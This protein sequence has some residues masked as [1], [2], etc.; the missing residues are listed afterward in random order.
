MAKMKDIRIVFFDVDGT[1]IDMKKKQISIRMLETLVRL[2]EKGVLLCLATGR[3]PMLLPHF[4]GVEFD[5]FLTFNGSYC[6]N[7]EE[8]ILDRPILR[9][10]VKRVIGNAA[11]I[12]RPVS[13]ATKA[14]LAA[15]GKD[16]DLVDYYAIAKCE[17]DVAEDFD[18]LIDH[19]NVYQ[20]MLGCRKEEYPALLRDVSGARIT[21]WWDRA[22]DVIP[23]G[24]GKG[25]GIEKILEY[26]GIDRSQALAFG[27]GSNDI[28]MLQTVGWSVA[29]GNATPNVKAAADDVCADVADDGIYHYCVEHALI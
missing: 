15:N 8:I 29:M 3:G 24:G 5:A 11:A 14:R 25:Y 26:Y 4:E 6:F 17:V 21:A 13:V 1:L 18:D 23:S 16:K 12:G 9:E 28:E 19:E 20:M 22:G 7:A 2:K 27:D 10:D